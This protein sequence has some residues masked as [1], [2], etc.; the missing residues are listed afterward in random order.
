MSNNWNWNIW[1]TLTHLYTRQWGTVF[2]AVRKMLITIIKWSELLAWTMMIRWYFNFAI[3]LKFV[4]HQLSSLDELNQLRQIVLII[5]KYY[6]Y[7]YIVL[8]IS[9]SKQFWSWRRFSVVHIFRLPETIL[10]STRTWDIF[11][12]FWPFK[13]LFLV[14]RHKHAKFAAN[15]WTPQQLEANKY[16]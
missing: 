11:L 4:L 15:L 2:M 10:N 8:V 13:S 7:I 16:T 6:N 3:M 9:S 12:E 1:R 14:S 5:T